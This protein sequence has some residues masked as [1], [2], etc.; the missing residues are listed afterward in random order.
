M[1]GEETTI[2]WAGALLFLLATLLF[3]PL[4]GRVRSK[5]WT[6]QDET[7]VFFITVVS[8]V[9]MALGL[10]VVTSADGQ[11]IYWSRWLFYMGSCAI[12]ATEVARIAG[13]GLAEIAEIGLLTGLVMFLGF[14]AS[15]V[16]GPGKWIFFGL[17]T[18][19]YLG[20][21]AL[22]LRWNSQEYVSFRK[23]LMGFI[24][25]FWSLFPVVWVLAP[26]GF[27]LISPQFEALLYGALDLITKIGFGLYILYQI[28]MEPAPRPA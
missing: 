17:S 16:I 9:V 10:A 18:L 25:V 13:K 4:E 23:P 8:Y 11:P 28:K 5:K 15:I 12:L 22:L 24:L 26:T 20:M 14:L 2:F 21:L 19:A 1:T 7:F 6:F 27:N 3:V